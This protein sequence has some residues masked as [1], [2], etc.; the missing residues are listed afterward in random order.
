MGK[1]LFTEEE[2]NGL[3]EMF[4]KLAEEMRD[5]PIMLLDEV[6]YPLE[7]NGVDK[8]K[9]KPVEIC[10]SGTPIGSLVKIRPVVAKGEEKK[11]YLGFY[12][13]D[14]MV[15]VIPSYRPKTKMIQVS[16]HNNPAIFVP[17]LKRIVWGMESWWGAVESEDELKE[18]TDED[19]DN[20]WY[21][22]LLKSQME[23]KDN[24]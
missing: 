3:Q 19:I 10:M 9:C 1:I 21:V 22:K 8:R 15:D 18:I 16:S 17:E 23:G 20:V 12:L 2:K 5:N 13:G 14:L 4:T 11:T 24:E 6:T 7:I